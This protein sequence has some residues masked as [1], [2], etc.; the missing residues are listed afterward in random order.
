MHSTNDK[1]I[2]K[3]KEEKFE[4]STKDINLIADWMWDYYHKGV[5]WKLG[6]LYNS[7]THST[8]SLSFS[9]FVSHPI[10]HSIGIIQDT[11]IKFEI[12]VKLN[13]VHILVAH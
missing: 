1:W 4:K 13:S 5:F 7:S 9:P 11:R 12:Y 2:F 6:V 10:T 8:G 3:E